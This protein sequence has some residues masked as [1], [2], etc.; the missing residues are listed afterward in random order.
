[1]GALIR[2]IPP[3]IQGSFH[4]L[5]S[6]EHGDETLIG[7]RLAPDAVLGSMVALMEDAGKRPQ[8]SSSQ[9]GSERTQASLSITGA[10]F[11]ALLANEADDDPFMQRFDAPSARDFVEKHGDEYAGTYTLGAMLAN[12][13]L[14][15]TDRRMLHAAAARIPENLRGL[16]LCD[17]KQGIGGQLQLSR[18]CIDPEVTLAQYDRGVLKPVAESRRAGGMGAKSYEHM[19]IRRSL[20]PDDLLRV[21]DRDTSVAQAT[22]LRA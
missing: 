6:N 20:S 18:F 19:S 9:H 10:E 1:M 17:M 2:K 11:E 4:I 22:Y 14:T 21:A 13:M 8:M 5:T 15:D 7:V 12:P 16:F 3:A